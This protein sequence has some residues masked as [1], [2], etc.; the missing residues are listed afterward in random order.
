MALFSN[1]IE[2]G[3]RASQPAA[4]AVS[5]GTLYFVTDEGVTERSNG[6]TW[7]SYST[8]T[9]STPQF[10]RVGIG[11][12]ADASAVLKMAGQYGSTTYDAG[13]SSTALTLNWNNGNTQLVTLTGNCTFT[14]SNPKDGFRYLIALKQDGTGSRAVTWPSAVKWSAGTAPTLSTAAGKVDVVTLVWLSGLGA[15]G[16]YIA[17]ANTDYTPA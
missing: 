14:L 16:N 7:D 15:S 1:L 5:T 17:A 2:R 6:T 4:T 9:S 8:T 12:A 3:T 10:A 13:N 11:V